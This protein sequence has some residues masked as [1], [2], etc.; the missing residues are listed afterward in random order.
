MVKRDEWDEGVV[1]NLRD[2]QLLDHWH[3]TR[4][5]VFKDILDCVAPSKDDTSRLPSSAIPVLEDISQNVNEPMLF[6]CVASYHLSLLGE[7]SKNSYLKE[8]TKSHLRKALLFCN[9]ATTRERRRIVELTD[10]QNNNEAR[11]I[12]DAR[13]KRVTVGDQ[14][15]MYNIKTMN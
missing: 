8:P 1:R 3:P 2:L 13:T 6:R 7:T 11:G 9:S 10:R 15:D 14:L 4:Y 5:L 12:G